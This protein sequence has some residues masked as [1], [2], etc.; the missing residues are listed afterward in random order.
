MENKAGK[1]Y[2]CPGAERESEEGQIGE[3]GAEETKLGEKS[4]K[5]IW[6]TISIHSLQNS[7]REAYSSCV[8]D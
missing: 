4:G 8:N 5:E 1:L 6:K 3:K 2:S 7:Q